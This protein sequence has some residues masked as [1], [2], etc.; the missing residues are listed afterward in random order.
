MLQ[1]GVNVKRALPLDYYQMPYDS[2]PMMHNIHNYDDIAM[3]LSLAGSTWPYLLDYLR[4]DEVQGQD[5]GRPD[6]GDG[7]G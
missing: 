1:M 2:L 6:G 7:S 5:R 3:V 4:R